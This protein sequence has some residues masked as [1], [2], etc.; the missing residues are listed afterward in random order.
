MESKPRLIAPNQMN[1]TS[2]TPI[3]PSRF[4]R[5]YQFYPPLQSR[6]STQP[7]INNWMMPI[8]SLHAPTPHHHLLPSTS[9][10]NQNHMYMLPFSNNNNHN[11]NNHVSFSSS[12]SPTSSHF[13]DSIIPRI[14]YPLNSPN[15]S[16]NLNSPPSSSSVSRNRHKCDWP[17]CTWSFKRLEHLKRHMITHTGER[18]YTCHYPGCGKK[19]GRSDN[20]AAHYKTHTKS[21][22][23][24]SRKSTNI[25]NNTTDISALDITLPHDNSTLTSSISGI[26]TIQ[27]PPPASPSSTLP[28]STSLT[29]DQIDAFHYYCDTTSA[30]NQNSR[31][32]ISENTT[33]P[34]DHSSLRYRECF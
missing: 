15:P 26:M 30:A 12:S 22:P 25:L 32:S 34:A 11:N 31:P 10:N 2:T 9:L 19:F 5:T 8:F 4:R 27:L 14:S 13:S 29:Q 21:N 17:G 24:R 7:I 18:K 20:F 23:R 3:D 6:D 16:S 1:S 33:T 28:S